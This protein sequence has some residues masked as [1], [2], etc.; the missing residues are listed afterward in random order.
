M[1]LISKDSS[2]YVAGHN[3]MVGRSLKNSLSKKSYNNLLLPTREDLDL[4]NNNDVENWFLRNK[5]DVVILAAAKVGGI[6]ANNKY[7]ADFILENLKIQTNVIEAS[8]KFKVNRL[9]FLG[10]SC[11]YPKSCPQPIKEEYLLEL[12]GISPGS[13][14]PFALLN[15]TENNIDL[16]LEDK[17]YES[18]YINFHP[19]TNKATVTIKSRE[20]IE[21]MIENK[22]KIHIFSTAKETIVKTYG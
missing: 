19:L 8:Y 5:P 21:F 4:L 9:L 16:Y 15:N 6:Y 10:S 22:K 2:I 14:T 12:L 3:G 20:F 7:P 1:T 11:I 18:E 13:V 17:M